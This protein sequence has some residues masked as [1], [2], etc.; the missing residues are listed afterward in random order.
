MRTIPH[1]ED[2]IA[3]LMDFKGF[4]SW[5]DDIHPVDQREI[6]KRLRDLVENE[7]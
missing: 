7:E 5:W 4:D 1:E 3:A 6:L 2:I